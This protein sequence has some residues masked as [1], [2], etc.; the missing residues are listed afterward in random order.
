MEMGKNKRFLLF[1]PGV[2]FLSCSPALCGT[3]KGVIRRLFNII[4]LKIDHLYIGN[5]FGGRGVRPS[6]GRSDRKAR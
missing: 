3:K 4:S 2:P 1:R 5:V 6:L